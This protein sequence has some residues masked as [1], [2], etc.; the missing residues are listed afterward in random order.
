MQIKPNYASSSWKVRLLSSLIMQNIHKHMRNW[1][2]KVNQK[3]LKG[4][5]NGL[6]SFNTEMSTSVGKV[7]H[8]S[9]KN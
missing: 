2:Y 1:F 6:R 4:V 5:G 8:T 9:K 7:Q 3:D